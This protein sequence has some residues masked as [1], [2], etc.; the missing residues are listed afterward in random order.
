MVCN[1]LF[2]AY[3]T[4]KNKDRLS[5]L[6]VLTDYAPRHYI[7]NQQA[8]SLLDEFKLADKA[9]VKVDAQIPVNTV[10]N[11]EDKRVRET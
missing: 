5:V 9:R 2:T 7:Y 1:D 10:M 4:P 11:Q 8:Q 3:F 6:D